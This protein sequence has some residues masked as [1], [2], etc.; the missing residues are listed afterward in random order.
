MPVDDAE[1]LLAAMLELLADP[2]LRDT[3]GR[4]ARANVVA[5]YSIDATVRGYLDAYRR[6]WAAR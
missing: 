2:A 1:A 4:K 5:R 3:L 6:G